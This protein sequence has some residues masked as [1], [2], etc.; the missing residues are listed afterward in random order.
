MTEIR[1]KFK[2]PAK[3][4]QDAALALEDYARASS[5]FDAA[6]VFDAR[7]LVTGVSLAAGKSPVP[8][9]V[10]Q[11][12]ERFFESLVSDAADRLGWS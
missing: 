6:V 1:V 10:A 4:G 5:T 8:D 12:I 11:D 9:A 2:T 7:R 3:L